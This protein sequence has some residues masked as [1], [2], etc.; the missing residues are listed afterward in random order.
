MRVLTSLLAASCL[1]TPAARAGLPPIIPRK[2]LFGNPVKTFPQISPDGKTLA[3]L[4]PDKKDVLQ[5]W[6]QTP[7]KDDARPVTSDK[8]RGIR[9]YAWAYAPDTLLY[10]QDNDGDENFHV[11]A[12]RISDGQ[13]RELTPFPGARAELLHLSPEHPDEVLVTANVQDKKTFD[14]YRITLSTGDHTLDTKNPGD[15]VGWEVDPK[16]KVR[17]AIAPTPDG[18]RQVRYRPDEKSPWTTVVTWGIEDADG[19]VLG[20]SADG[21]SLW[22]T[23]SVNRDTEALVK[24]NL[25]AGKDEVLASDPHADV[26]EVLYNPVK[27]EVEAVAFNRERIRWQ[28]LDPKIDAD[29]KALAAGAKGEPSVVSHD[30][31]QDKWVVGYSADTEPTV[32]YL[33]DRPTKKLTKL[34]DAQPELS[35]YTLAPMKPVIIKARDGLELVSYLT[36]PDGV[37]PKSLPLVLLVHGGPWGRDRWG[38]N[39]QAQWLANRGYAVLSVNYRAS[40]GFGKKFLHAG[41]REWAGKM[42]DD[43][44]DAVDW[45]VKQGYADPKHIAIMGGSYGG[46]AALV[47]VTFTPDVFC[48]AVDVVGPSNLVTLLKSIPP[49]W[50]PMRKTFSLRVGDPDKDEEFLKSRSPLFKAD[51]IKV[52]LLIGQGANDPRVKQAESEQIVAALRKANKPVEYILFPD[53]GHGFARPEN[54]LKF[55]AAAETFLA[56]HLPGG[57]AE[58]ESETSQTPPATRAPRPDLPVRSKAD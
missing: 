29:L 26:A 39:S 42:H 24:H 27:H 48:C 20:F 58:P 15:V 2:I 45:A 41:D 22:M 55:F 35:R 32:Y 13:T 23:T 4:A 25:S 40:A 14:V 6:V 52:P 16:F 53:E 33:Y 17:A 10:M 11:F 3:F 50:A 30:L 37:E 5:V 7:G 31:A 38:Y 49:Y 51:Q 36:L 18:G 57:R 54:R 28:A 34:F 1:L 8:K 9:Q 21:A 46:Y 19:N 47:G 43:L 12:T 56:K 44:L